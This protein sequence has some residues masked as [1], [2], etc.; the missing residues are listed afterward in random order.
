MEQIA[1]ANVKFGHEFPG[2]VSLNVRNF[3]RDAALSELTA[4]IKAEGILQPMLAINQGQLF[5]VVDGNRRLAALR[6]LKTDAIPVTWLHISEK[7]TV[8]EALAQ[9]LAAN[10][11]RVPL[12]EVDRFEAFSAL[13]LPVADIASRFG[14]DAVLVRRALALGKLAPEVRKLWRD[15]KLPGEDARAFTVEPDHKKQIDVLTRLKKSGNLYSHAIK[16][17]LV[18]DQHGADSLLKYVGKAE[19]LKAGGAIGEDLF[20][21][22]AD[23][24]TH[25]SD[26]TKLQ[27]MAREKINATVARL[28]T[29]GWG[30]A[31]Y[32]GDL[33]RE[34]EYNWQRIAKVKK[35]GRAKLGC[36]VVIDGGKESIIEG[37]IKPG[38][39]VA[40]ETRAEKKK[41]KPKSEMSGALVRRLEEQAAKALQ[42]ALSTELTVGH[43]LVYSKLLASMIVPHAIYQTPHQLRDKMKALRD[44]L[45]S[46]AMQG[47]LFKRFDRADYFTAAP[48]AAVLKAIIETCG[49]DAVKP[50]A[51]KPRGVI[52]KFASANVSKDWLPPAMRH[53]GY[54]PPK[55]KK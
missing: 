14:V 42:D 19:Y 29:E 39:K 35:D 13:D 3:E 31:A 2:D 52:T 6:K 54:K 23:E 50:L 5:Y 40:A 10:I 20:A 21:R 41:D 25:V 47:H 49:A 12:H 28:E 22:D 24:S 45:P 7:N 16:K 43:G 4:S 55:V 33:P 15:G 1:L 17:A 37:V 9:G 51:K 32:A 26:V 48:K 11:Q 8:G 36:V 30:W 53:K 27:D 18:G 44:D 38:A 34:W 46:T